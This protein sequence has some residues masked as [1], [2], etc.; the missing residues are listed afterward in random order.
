[1]TVAAAAVLAKEKEF[2]RLYAFLYTKDYEKAKI[3]FKRA[4]Q[5]VHPDH[6]GDT[7]RARQIIAAWDERK[8]SQGWEKPAPTVTKSE[9]TR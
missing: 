9:E 4:M 7:E 2:K 3:A 1:V 6:G 5:E 8:R